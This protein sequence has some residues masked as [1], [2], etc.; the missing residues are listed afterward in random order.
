MDDDILLAH[1][2]EAIAVE[3]ADA[4]GEAAVERLEQEIRPVGDDQLR[5]VGERQEAVLHEHGVLA[6]LQLLDD[7]ALQAVGHR[8]L[9]LQADH[10]TAAPALQGRLER[11]HQILGFFLDLDVTVAQHAEGALAL[12]LEAGEQLGDEQADHRLERG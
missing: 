11:A 7:E 8:R 10:V 5:G 3:F 9:E 1:G 6:H 2:G 4:L 12:D